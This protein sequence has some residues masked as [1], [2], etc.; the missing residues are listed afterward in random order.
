[1]IDGTADTKPATNRPTTTPAMCGIT[2]AIVHAR[3][4]T[5]DAAM[6]THLRPKASEYGGNITPPKA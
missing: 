2:P 4:Y 5:K 3:Q 1:M 6:Y